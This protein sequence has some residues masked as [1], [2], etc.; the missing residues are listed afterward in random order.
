MTN[1][2]RTIYSVTKFKYNLDIY[3]NV[4][5]WWWPYIF[6]EIVRFF[7]Q[8]ILLMGLMWYLLWH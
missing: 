7:M 1:N 6:L 4:M 8:Q 5:W 3:R 2:K